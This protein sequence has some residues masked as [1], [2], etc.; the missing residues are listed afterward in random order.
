MQYVQTVKGDWKELKG[1]LKSRYTN[2]SDLD[3]ES[4]ETNR[5]QMMDALSARLG[6]TRQELIRILNSL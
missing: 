1:K 4:G 2:L 6:K 3:L 5:G